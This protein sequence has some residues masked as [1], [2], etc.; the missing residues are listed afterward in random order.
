MNINRVD[1]EVAGM[2]CNHCVQTIKT[3]LEKLEGVDQVEV[4]LELGRAR[5]KGKDLVPEKINKTIEELGFI[6]GSMDTS[7]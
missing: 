4:I 2:S 1:M 7:S 6:P 3:A 5:I